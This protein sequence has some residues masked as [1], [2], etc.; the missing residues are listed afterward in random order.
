MKK[1]MLGRSGLEVSAIGLGCMGMSGVY[2][3]AGERTAMVSLIRDAV[4]EGVTLFDT[5]EV[6]GPFINEELVGEALA[7]VRDKVVISTKF[8]YALETAVGG[9][10]PT[11]LNSRPDNIKA[12]ADASLKRLRT[13]RIDLFFQHRVDPAVPIEEVASAVGELVKAGKVLHFGLSEASADTIRRAHAIHP[14]AAVQS[15]YS[16]WSREPEEEIFG[17]LEELGIGFISY[18]PLGRGFL[19]GA[20]NAETNF[21]ADDFRSYLPRFA[22]AAR[23]QNLA[24]V[25]ALARIAR[26]KDATVA[27]VALAWLLAKRPWIVPIPGTRKH[28]RMIENIGAVNVTLTA[29]D[30]ESIDRDHPGRVIG[31]RYGDSDMAMV[32]G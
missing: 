6:Y 9:A 1:R 31:A 22:S 27:Q 30:L 29:N 16:L 2:G 15:E 21:G 8:G 14:V 5:A 12:V 13:D 18:S 3:Q 7:R 25:E 20:V 26:R 28:S 19:A 11:Q 32:N 23:R 4:D 24:L 10:W 17:V